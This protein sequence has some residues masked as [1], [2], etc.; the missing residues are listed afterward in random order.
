MI[1]CAREQPVRSPTYESI[2]C[3]VSAQDR[4]LARVLAPE[5]FAGRADEAFGHELDKQ[6]STISI[7]CSCANGAQALSSAISLETWGKARVIYAGIEARPT[8][9]TG[10][11][12]RASNYRPKNLATVSASLLDAYRRNRLF[13]CNE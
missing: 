1:T 9:D 7:F 3:R 13:A 5:V 12:C 4:T 6:L 2:L 10:M 8:L 11:G